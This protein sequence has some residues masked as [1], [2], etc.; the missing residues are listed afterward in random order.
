[1]KHNGRLLTLLALLGFLAAYPVHGQTPQQQQPAAPET[2]QGS[3][4]GDPIRQLNL[5]PEQREQIRSIREHNK[6]ERAQINDRVRDSNRALEEALNSDNPDEAVVDQRVR[7]VAAAQGAAMR[8][9]ILTEV[10][11][12]RVLTVEQRNLLRSLQQQA[13]ANRRERLLATPEERQ[14]RREDRSRPLQNQRNGIG[15][16]LPR[17]QNQRRPRL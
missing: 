14:Q 1:M 17:G 15:P 16:L 11:I 9:R 7:D 6:E 13:Q 8:M 12:R 10:R 2:Q 3:A 4:G 5:T